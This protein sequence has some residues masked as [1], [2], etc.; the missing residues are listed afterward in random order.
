MKI[1]KYIVFGDWVVSKSGERHY[2]SAPQLARLYKLER[3]ACIFADIS[4]PKTLQGLPENLPRFYPL[5]DG[6]YT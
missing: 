2:V 6:S 4:R 3:E 5:R 1:K